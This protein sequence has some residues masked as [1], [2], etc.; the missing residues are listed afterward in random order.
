MNKRC[1]GC[2]ELFDEKLEVCPKCGYIEGTPVEE[3]IHIIPGSLL[4]NRYII[5][6]VLGYG[7]FGVTYIAWDGKLERKVA[8]KEY[9]PSEFST[10][11][12]G[13]SCLTIFSGDREEQFK[14]GLKKFVDEAKRLAKFNS[15]PGIVSIFD[16]FLEN[17]TAYI[18]MEFLDGETLG[19]RLK[20][21]KTEI[22]IKNKNRITAL[23]PF[24]RMKL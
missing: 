18:V 6:R 24:P 16:S 17:D 13:Q 2:M 3:A 20:R 15:E 22:K 9:M 23:C 19:D 7:S 11:M 14:D 1:M 10:R 12:P 5:G 21:E 8:I 4:H